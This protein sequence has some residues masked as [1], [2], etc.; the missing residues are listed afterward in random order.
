MVS[1][2]DVLAALHEL[3]LDEFIKPCKGMMEGPC[4]LEW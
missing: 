2:S 3:D 1:A 4:R